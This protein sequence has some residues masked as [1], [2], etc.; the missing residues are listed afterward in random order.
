MIYSLK[1]RSEVLWLILKWEINLE[2]LFIFD[3]LMFEK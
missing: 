2:Y 3:L 1:A